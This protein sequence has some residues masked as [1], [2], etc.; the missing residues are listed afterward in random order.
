MVANQPRGDD[1]QGGGNTTAHRGSLPDATHDS[2]GGKG[3]KILA[4]TSPGAPPPPPLG[5]PQVPD[6]RPGRK[7]C[8]HPQCT[9][10]P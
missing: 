7:V 5:K 1:L 9:R 2:G 6:P 10:A 3:A 4:G 8:I